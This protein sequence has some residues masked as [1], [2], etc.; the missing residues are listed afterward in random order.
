MRAKSP[1]IGVVRKNH[2][3]PRSVRLAAT[4]SLVRKGMP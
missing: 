1:A 2:L 3:K 4:D